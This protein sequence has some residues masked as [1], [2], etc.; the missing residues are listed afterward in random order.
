[1][2]KYIMDFSEIS[3][4]LIESCGGKGTYLG[5]LIKAGFNVPPGFCIVSDAYFDML[6]CNKLELLID[7]IVQ[8][9]NFENYNEEFEQKTQMIRDLVAKCELPSE[10][11]QIS[12]AYKDL[13]GAGGAEPYV[14]V[15]SSVAV[16]GTAISSFPGMM[17]TYHYIRGTEEVFKKVKECWASVWTARAAMLRYQKGIDHAMAVIAPVIQRMVDPEVAGVMFTGNPIN[18]SRDEIVI[19]STWGLGEAVVSGKVTSDFFLLD[20]ESL[21][22][23]NK[24]I[25]SKEIRF[26]VDNETGCGRKEYAVEPHMRK[27]PSLTVEQLVK[28]AQTGKAI[29]TYFSTP[30]DIEWAFEKGVL[31]FLQTRKI[32]RF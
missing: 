24:K 19:E 12:N 28:L 27:K 17:D 29:E 22:V 31:Y 20:K 15:R 25:N 7:E 8:T 5:E 11:E 16:K 1:M 13:A 10:Y 26:G 21:Q 32:L 30:Q 9:I 14:A 18:L 23:K 6:K 3:V 2:P 4:D